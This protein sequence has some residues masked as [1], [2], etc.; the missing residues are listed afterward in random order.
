[1]VFFIAAAVLACVFL[2]FIRS[3]KTSVPEKATWAGEA[4]PLERMHVSQEWSRQYL[5]LRHQPYQW[6][7]YQQRAERY[8]PFFEEK[9]KKAGLPEDIK[10]LAVAESAL[11]PVITS[12]AG[13]AG[14]WQFMPSTA[15]R[16]GLRVDATIDERLD[17]EKATDAA[18]RYLSD[19]YERFDSWHLAAAGYN[20]G[21]NG[22]GRDLAASGTTD[23]FEADLPTETQQYLFRIAAIKAVME[24]SSLPS[25][26]A[27]TLP[28]TTTVTIEGPTNLVRLSDRYNMGVRWLRSLNPQFVSGWVPPGQWDITI[29]K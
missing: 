15:R 28:D 29:P 25:I 16:Y 2:F 7:L 24:D 26:R 20:R 3:E 11:R 12:H 8:F 4:F 5:L 19:L 18:I 13:A 1:M 6:L 10:Y 22:L 17:T 21:E 27:L 23:Y 14:L 9:L